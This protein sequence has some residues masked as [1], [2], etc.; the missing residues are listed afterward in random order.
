MTGTDDLRR[1]LDHSAMLESMADG[2]NIPNGYIK[3]NG[4]VEHDSEEERL[5]ALRQRPG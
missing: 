4:M 2:D 3:E 1:E 5:K